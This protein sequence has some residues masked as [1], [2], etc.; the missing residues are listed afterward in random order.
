MLSIFVVDKQLI[1]IVVA[2]LCGIGNVLHGTAIV[3]LSLLVG[4]VL[5]SWFTYRQA[6]DLEP[7]ATNQS[8]TMGKTN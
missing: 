5:F 3:F 7:T 8:T 1:K 4:I 2:P 6:P